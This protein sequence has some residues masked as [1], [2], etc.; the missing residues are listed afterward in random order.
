MQLDPILTLEKAIATAH[1]SKVVH[2]HQEVVSGASH[3]IGE[4]EWL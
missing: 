3:S 4:L 2:E 1:Q